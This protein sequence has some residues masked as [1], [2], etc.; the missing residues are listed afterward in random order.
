MR[1]LWLLAVS[2]CW[3]GPTPPSPAPV[4]AVVAKPAEPDEPCRGSNLQ[5]GLVQ[6]SCA[7]HGGDEA[8]PEVVHIELDASPMTVDGGATRRSAIVLRNTAREDVEV[9][10]DD[11]CGAAS[12]VSAVIV[13]ANGDRVDITG[14]QCGMGRGCSSSTVTFTLRPS[15][16]L[17]IPFVVDGRLETYDADCQPQR[18]GAV[19]AGQ[20]RLLVYSS[21][22]EFDVPITI[23]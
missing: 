12:E 15:G 17:R 18:V 5:I 1:A 8:I 7:D 9:S 13:D 23:Y 22:K 6:A 16:T 10:L 19:P 20:Y 3:R 11:S 21:V 2:G 14:P 4:P